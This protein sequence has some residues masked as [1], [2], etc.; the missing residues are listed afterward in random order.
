MSIRK[1]ENNRMEPL[2]LECPFPVVRY[3]MSLLLNSVSLF[4]ESCEKTMSVASHLKSGRRKKCSK[5]S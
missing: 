2:R 4:L 3:I 1:R 5:I